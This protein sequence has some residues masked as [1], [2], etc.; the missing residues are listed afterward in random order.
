MRTHSPRR[1]SHE[2][3]SSAQASLPVRPSPDDVDWVDIAHALSQICCYGGRTRKFY[4]VAEHC[5]RIADVMPQ[6]KIYGLLHDAYKGC[7]GDI[8]PSSDCEIDA[9]SI[10]A[11]KAVID[12]KI[13]RAAHLPHLKS[14]PALP[15]VE[16]A[17]KFL[18]VTEARDLL[19]ALPTW[20]ER[21]ELIEPL[22][23]DGRL[24]NPW[25]PEFAK[26]RWLQLLAA[27]WPSA[28]PNV[29][30]YLAEANNKATKELI[31]KYG[32]QIKDGRL[33]SK[34]GRPVNTTATED[35]PVS[36]L[37]ADQYMESLGVDMRS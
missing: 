6:Y 15:L 19:V 33:I 12:A 31:A 37:R 21:L 11:Q 9:V 26:F 18:I 27:L 1:D 36:L 28:P 4:S 17:D 34:R 16:W 14:H 7:M 2:P 29:A 8:D 25:D 13:Y 10:Y 35:A 20:D 23:P 5:V 30:E 32:Y 22:Q 24:S 3:R